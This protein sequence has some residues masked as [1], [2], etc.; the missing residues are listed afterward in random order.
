MVAHVS[1]RL[2]HRG[3]EG[4]GRMPSVPPAGLVARSIAAA[5]VAATLAVGA[6]GCGGGSDLPLAEVRG[7]VTYK[8]KPLDKGDVVFAPR[9]GPPAL[10]RPPRSSPTAPT[11]S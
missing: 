8:G 11:G 9:G 4:W 3:G 10:R 5:F 6:L 1:S 2:D 7:V